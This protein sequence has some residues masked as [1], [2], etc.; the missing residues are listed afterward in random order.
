VEVVLTNKPGDRQRLVTELE[1]FARQVQLPKAALQAADL[2]LEEHLTNVI[3]YGFE[4]KQIHEILVRL[5]I[6]GNAL[7]VEVFDDGHP[8]NPLQRPEVD[9]SIPLDEK[10]I[11]G[12][13]VH[14]MRKFMD[15][16]DYRREDGKNVF[17]MRK[18]L[19][20]D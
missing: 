6:Q 2:A 14:L 17:R 18:K 12:L 4:D 20:P 7:L 5:E 10:P 1:A 16:L 9:T 13:G 8:F 3:N 11:G 19:K 15:E